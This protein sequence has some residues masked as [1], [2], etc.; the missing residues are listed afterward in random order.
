[1]QLSKS[2]KYREII[3]PEFLEFPR[4]Q[5]NV[6]ETDIKLI[7][8]RKWSSGKNPTWWST[9]NAVKHDRTVNYTAGNLEC[10]LNGFA[11]LM[12]A[13]LYNVYMEDDNKNIDVI[14]RKASRF[15]ETGT[16]LN[17]QPA[18]ILESYRILV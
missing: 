6:L 18:E 7:P 13:I 10:V 17:F 12:V 3:L 1:M 5:I 11:G 2:H 14:V 4:L 8:W 16:E 9:Y 15:F